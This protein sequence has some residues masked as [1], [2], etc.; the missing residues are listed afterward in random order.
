VA[1]TIP[2]NNLDDIYSKLH[3]NVKIVYVILEERRIEILTYRKEARW[4]Y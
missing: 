3:G 1:N 4:T 2:I